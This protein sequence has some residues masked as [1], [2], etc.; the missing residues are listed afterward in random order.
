MTEPA[1][2]LPLSESV[3]SPLF[4]LGWDFRKTLLYS[5]GSSLNNDAYEMETMNQGINMPEALISDGWKGICIWGKNAFGFRGEV[6]LDLDQQ[7]SHSLYG[8]R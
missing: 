8:G 2:Y 4:R 6:C 5:G 3:R 7:N 1:F